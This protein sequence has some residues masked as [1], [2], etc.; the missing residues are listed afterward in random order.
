VT[1]VGAADFGFAAPIVFLARAL[2][3]ANGLL[4]LLG[5]LFLRRQ[6]LRSHLSKLA[7]LSVQTMPQG[8]LGPELLQEGL[9]TGKGL[10]VD[11]LIAK[12]RSPRPLDFIFGKQSF[13]S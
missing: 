7:Q 10:F 2:L 8:A 1:D 9:G 11:L 5:R 3:P 4:L 13:T 6:F 12:K